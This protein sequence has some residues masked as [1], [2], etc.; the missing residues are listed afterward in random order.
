MA[1]III[2]NKE[3]GLDRTSKLLTRI[4]YNNYVKRLFKFF[5]VQN[6][7]GGTGKRSGLI[8]QRPNQ[9]LAGSSFLTE[10]PYPAHLTLKWQ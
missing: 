2:I 7:V 1:K 4:L 8:N 10:I 5:G 3:K 9:G 6:W